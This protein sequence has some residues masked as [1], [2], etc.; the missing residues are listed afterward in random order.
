MMPIKQSFGALIPHGDSITEEQLDKRIAAYYAEAGITCLGCLNQG[1]VSE[2]YEYQEPW[3]DKP[4]RARRAVTCPE[5]NGVRE[6][7]EASLLRRLYTAG[8]AQTMI[9]KWSFER[10]DLG[11]NPDMAPALRAA[12]AYANHPHGGLVL[13]GKPGR[14]KTHLAVAAL[15]VIVG[16]G[17][18]GIFAEARGLLSRLQRGIQEGDYQDTL[19]WWRAGA[20]V[21]ALDDFGA[22]RGTE[23]AWEVIEDIV[24]YRHARDKAFILTTNIGPGETPERLRSR[25]SDHSAVMLVHCEGKDVRP[26][27][28]A[29]S[30]GAW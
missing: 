11:L 23:W 29:E 3:M 20:S 19:D 18:T 10:F 21:I 13:A 9:D 17:L 30:T 25:F 27:L 24:T 4:M 22:Q 6:T 16:N 7:P 1:T 28:K 26:E 5:C 2:E 14:G 15:Q 12:Q 8:L